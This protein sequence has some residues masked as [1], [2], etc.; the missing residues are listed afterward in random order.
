MTVVIADLPAEFAAV[1][2]DTAQFWINRAVAAIPAGKW[3]CAGV[4]PDEGVLLKACHL[5]KEDGEGTGPAVPAGS[6]TGESRGGKSVSR[7][8]GA[9]A[10]GEHGSTVYG[11]A[12]D[13]IIARVR[14]TRRNRMPPSPQPA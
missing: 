4:D 5:L 7:A 6:I 1:D 11:Q 8:A 14:G 13:N 12:L 3:L 10:T 9:A 2:P